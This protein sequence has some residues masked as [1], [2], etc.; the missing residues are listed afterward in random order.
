[1]FESRPLRVGDV[2]SWWETVTSGKFLPNAL[3]EFGKVWVGAAYVSGHSLP[4]KETFTDVR[5]WLA[6]AGHPLWPEAWTDEYLRE[7]V[8]SETS[9]SGS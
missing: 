5:E 8:G 1:M 3:A 9:G 7:L 2:D 6:Q 4:I